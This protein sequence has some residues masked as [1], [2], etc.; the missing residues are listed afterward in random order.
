MTLLVTRKNTKPKPEVIKK[1]DISLQ[2]KNYD[3]YEYKTCV[4]ENNASD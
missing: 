3:I 2:I 1:I 4:F